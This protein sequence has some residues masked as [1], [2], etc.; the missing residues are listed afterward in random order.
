[1]PIKIT[2]SSAQLT[3]LIKSFCIIVAAVY[4]RRR[5]RYSSIYLLGNFIF[6]HPFLHPAHGK[7]IVKRREQ[8]VPHAI[9]RLSTGAWIMADGNFCDRETL[10]LEQRRQE[11]MHPFE[12]F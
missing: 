6:K 7:Q 1:M 5:R 4:D 11:P 8:P 9:M 3:E 10:N 12:K 2:T